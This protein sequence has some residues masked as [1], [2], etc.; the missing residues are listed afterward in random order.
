MH[1]KEKDRSKNSQMLRFNLSGNPSKLQL[2]RKKLGLIV[3]KY[4][5]M[6]GDF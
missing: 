2:R 1:Q 4:E 6:N 5:L 3:N